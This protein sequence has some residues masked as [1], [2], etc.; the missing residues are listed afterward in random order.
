MPSATLGVEK[1]T[2]KWFIFEVTRMYQQNGYDMADITRLFPFTH[3]DSTNEAGIWLNQ[4]M[5]ELDK[6]CS[7]KVILLLPCLVKQISG[8]DR[9]PLSTKQVEALTPHTG[10]MR[11]QLKENKPDDT[12]TPKTSC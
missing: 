6:I 3:F 10:L 11:N 1:P 2:P 7:Y 4:N 9:V 8:F 5:Q 12:Q